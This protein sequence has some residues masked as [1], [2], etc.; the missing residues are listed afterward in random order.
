M[1]GLRRLVAEQ[2]PALVRGVRG[3]GL[4]IGVEFASGEIAEA[5]QW[6]AFRRGLLVLEAGENVV[7]MS[8]PLIVSAD[9]VATAVRL[10]GEAVAAV[11]RDPQ[12]AIREAHEGGL[13][14]EVESAV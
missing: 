5:V 3:K 13:T 2:F 9:E 10:F 11:D 14:G 12:A 8:P 7:R 4:M 6:Q 1:S